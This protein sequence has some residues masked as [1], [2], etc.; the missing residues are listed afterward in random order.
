MELPAA[1]P[2]C[3]LEDESTEHALLH[4]P[5]VSLI[6]RWWVVSLGG[7]NSGPWLYLFLNVIRQ[8]MA[9]GST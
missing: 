7:A 9:K 2:I 5:R 4:Y 8:S 6:W 1:C 3:G